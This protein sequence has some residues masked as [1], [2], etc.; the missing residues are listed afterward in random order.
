MGGRLL[1]S[2]TTAHSNVD[3]TRIFVSIAAYRDPELPRT[4]CSMLHHA[5]RPQR[6]FVA[7][8]WQGDEEPLSREDLSKIAHLWG[9]ANAGRWNWVPQS[10]ELL[11]LPFGLRIERRLLLGGHDRTTS[12]DCYSGAMLGPLLG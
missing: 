11:P 7:V 2:R 3:D 6:L 8:I 1:S 4:L 10:P 5:A 9:I 12:Q